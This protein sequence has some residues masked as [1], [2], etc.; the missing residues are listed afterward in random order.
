ML[1][2]FDRAVLVFLILLVV[3]LTSC[4]LGE[5]GGAPPPGAAAQ[6]QGRRPIPALV[7]TAILRSLPSEISTVGSLRSPETTLVSADISGIIV[8]LDAPAG[9][10]IQRGH[11]IARVGNVVAPMPAHGPTTP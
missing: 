9:R 3:S 7:T 4:S 2:I 5:R 8:S 6:P 1:H 10:E 11:L